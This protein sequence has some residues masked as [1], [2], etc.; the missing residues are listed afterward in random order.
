MSNPFWGAT[1]WLDAHLERSII[2]VA[3]TACAGII[4]FEVSRRFLLG[5]QASWSTTIPAYM[6]VWLTWPGAAYGVKVRAHLAFSDFRQRLPR[7]GQYL[8]LQLDYILFIVF[9]SV[10]VYFSIDLLHV[11]YANG[12]VV[13]G[14][15]SVPAWWFYLATPVGWGLLVIRVFQNAYQDFLALRTGAPLNLGGG[16]AAID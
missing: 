15:L 13:P 4:S 3:F 10:A 14:T 6:F 1:R 9:A 11:Q 5:E 16:I 7:N 12:S 2:L 8:L